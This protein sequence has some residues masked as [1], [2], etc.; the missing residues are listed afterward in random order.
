MGLSKALHP[1]LFLKLVRQYEVTSN[2]YLLN[3]IASG[4]P[5][6]EVFCGVLLVAGVAVRGAALVLLVLLAGFTPLILRRALGLAAACA[7]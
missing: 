3:A 1:D 5:W 4:L 7:W 2:P 6:F